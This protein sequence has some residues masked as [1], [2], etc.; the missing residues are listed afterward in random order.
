MRGS[1][2]LHYS[3]SRQKHEKTL[4]ALAALAATSAFA[5]VTITGVVEMGF[6]ATHH[7][8]LLNPLGSATPSKP[9]VI[10]N[11]LGL[12]ANGKPL[13][14]SSGLGVDTAEI[15][16]KVIE[17]LGA[18][19]KM[20]A[21][22]QFDTVARSGV[23]GGDT[24]MTLLTPVGALAL[25]S[26][27]VADWLSTGPANI[28]QLG[29]DG[30]TNASRG[31]QD[32]VAFVTKLAPTTTITLSHGENAQFGATT[33]GLGLGSGAAGLASANAGAFGQNQRNNGVALTYASGPFIANA[34]YLSYD[35]S[36][37]GYDL[38]IKSVAR[39]QASYDFG[40]AKVFAGLIN[41]TLGG[42]T[43]VNGVL[44]LGVPTG[45]WYF[46]GSLNNSVL[47][48]TS[49]YLGPIFAS[50]LYP[51]LGCSP[52]AGCGANSLDSN[53]AGYSLSA[54]YNFS[55]STNAIVSY[56]NWAFNVNAVDRDSEFEVALVK[57][58]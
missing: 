15:D 53:T 55:K 25:Q 14:D 6:D 50:T 3:Y 40:P 9:G 49:G 52:T 57:N 11:A 29:M 4:I 12:N 34:Q 42:G 2:H 7:S 32:V 23:V 48:G 21:T 46:T 56:R 41:T 30:R 39:A 28:G 10:G 36:T 16:F 22:M 35:Q 47:S 24:T 54:Q 31:Y 38:S 19:Y 8:A 27:R 18:G 37:D 20:I 51:A 5:Q 43:L 44:A 33:A 13:G 17:D 58:F 1:N 26:V 45:N